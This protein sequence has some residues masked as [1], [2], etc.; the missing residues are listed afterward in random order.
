METTATIISASEVKKKIQN[1]EDVVLIDTLS[2]ESFCS[3]HIPGSINI[4]TNQIQ[5][6]AENILPYKSQQLIV[7]CKNAMCRKSTR[8]AELLAELAYKNVIQFHGG[9]KEWKEAGYKFEG[10]GEDVDVKC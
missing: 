8:A 3:M 1:N 5:E 7:Y 6:Y 9:L 2:K 10:T 4:P